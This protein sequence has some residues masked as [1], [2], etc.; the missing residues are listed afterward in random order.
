MEVLVDLPVVFPVATERMA[1]AAVY[2][3]T[4][5]YQITAAT[6]ATT[7]QPPQDGAG[8]AAE[9]GPPS[10]AAGAVISASAVA[11]FSVS[12]QFRSRDLSVHTALPWGAETTVS[13]NRLDANRTS[14]NSEGIL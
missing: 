11:R 1:V 9:P 8:V 6:S 5:E 3:N 10:D 7:K 13:R 14:S 12:G 2:A 4:S